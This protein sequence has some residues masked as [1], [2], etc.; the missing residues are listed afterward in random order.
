M[1]TTTDDGRDFSTICQ[2]FKIEG[3]V[4]I[5][6]GELEKSKYQDISQGIRKVKISRFVAFQHY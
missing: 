5:S 6:V 3:K 4:K 2:K 1:T